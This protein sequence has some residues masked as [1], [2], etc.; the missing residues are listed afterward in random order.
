MFKV[1]KKEKSKF[2]GF[3][4]SLVSG[5]EGQPTRLQVCFRGYWYEISVPF[6]IEP[7]CETVTYDHEQGTRSYIQEHR[8]EYGI[9]ISEENVFVY[10]GA[11]Y[12][13]WPKNKKTLR[14]ISI[15]WRQTTHKSWHQFECWKGYP[16]WKNCI[17][18][19]EF[20]LHD[21]VRYQIENLQDAFEFGNGSPMY[22]FFDAADP[23]DGTQIRVRA[24]VSK[25]VWWKGGKWLQ[26]VFRL[27][28]KPIVRKSYWF[29]FNNEVGPRK[30]SWKGGTIGIGID[31]EDE[32][33]TETAES[34]FARLVVSGR[35]N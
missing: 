13:E 34:A 19:E 6:N 17:T 33:P 16:D 15:P 8:K 12:N 30:G 21:R 29:D 20:N 26:H 9:S 28:N 35:L 11:Q 27:F 1:L 3:R 2:G 7:E 31:I 24:T 25:M 14:S 23:Y 32:N 10:C 22:Y 18:K 4:F 5:Y